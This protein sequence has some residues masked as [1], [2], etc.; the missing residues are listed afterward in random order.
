MFFVFF[1]HYFLATSTTIEFKFLQ[2]CYFIICLDIPSEKNGLWQLPK[3]SRAFNNNDI[4]IYFGRRVTRYR[5]P[6]KNR[7]IA[8]LINA[9]TY[10]PCLWWMHK[11]YLLPWSMWYPQ[12]GLPYWPLSLLY[13]ASDYSND[14]SDSLSRLDLSKQIIIIII[15]KTC[16]APPIQ[17]LNSFWG[18]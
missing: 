14:M 3:V 11:I 9:I 16:K 17:D 18:T 5:F 12:E 10:Q 4:T 13:Q 8:S 6:V 1:L 7:E 15:I 2:V